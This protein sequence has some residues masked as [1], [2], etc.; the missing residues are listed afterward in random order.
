M[1]KAC[2]RCGKELE[3]H[4]NAKYCSD[5]RK[6]IRR[7]YFRRYY[8]THREQCL[9]NNRRWREENREVA[10]ENCRCWRKNN[11]ERVKEI[12]HRYYLKRK[13]RSNSN[14]NHRTVG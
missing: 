11:P 1:I 9:A 10:A 7:E 4:P 5:C 8:F 2:K 3:M 12:L 13:Q 6:E 14:E